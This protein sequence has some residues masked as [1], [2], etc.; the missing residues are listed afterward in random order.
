VRRESEPV[1]SAGSTRSTRSTRDPTVRRCRNIAGSTTRSSPTCDRGIVELHRVLVG[2]HRT[3]G[4]AFSAFPRQFPRHPGVSLHVT[5]VIPVPLLSVIRDAVTA[6]VPL[7]RARSGRT[8]FPRARPPA[9]LA[10]T[11][12]SS[13]LT[14]RARDEAV[15]SPLTASCRDRGIKT[16]PS[17]GDNPCDSSNRDDPSTNNVGVLGREYSEPSNLL[18]DSLA[19]PRAESAEPGNASP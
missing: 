8:G 14:S 18:S 7:V 5:S 1:R 19:R 13:G 10:I 6:A 3:S 11:L 9:D 15:A 16:S 4:S 2:Q 12:D 17:C